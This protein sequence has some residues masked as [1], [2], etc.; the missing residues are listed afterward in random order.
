MSTSDITVA[1]LAASP[2][3]FGNVLTWTFSDPRNGALPNIALDAVEVWSSTTNDRSTA[4]KVVEG[5][6]STTHQGI[7]GE[8]VYYYWIKPRDKI[9]SYGDWYPSGATSGIACRAIGTSGLAFALMNGYVTA[10]VT[11]NALT[12]SVKTLG[13]TDP[14]ATDFISISFANADGTYTSRR[15]TTALSLVV[16][17]GSTLGTQNS[18]PFQTW[19]VIFDDAGTLRIA[20]T[21]CTSSG[22]IYPI[23]DSGTADAFAEGG[24]G[25]AD[26]FATFYANAAITG[27]SYRIIGSARWTSGL[28]VA[29]VWSVNPNNIKQFSLGSQTPGAI[30]NESLFINSILATG[31]T[32][33]PDDNTIPTVSEGF[34]HTNTPLVPTP[35]NVI[36]VEVQLPCSCTVAGTIIGA[37]NK[38]GA[39]IAVGRA[40]IS[41]ANAVATISIYFRET[42]VSGTVTYSLRLGPSS[43][44]TLTVNGVNSAGKFGGTLNSKQRFT[45]YLG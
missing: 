1:A 17:N 4:S 38:G 8:T 43:A 25:N 9:G 7:I 41:V 28:S 30:V 12:I 29:G 22:I 32:V 44:G 16:S 5:I 14:T 20:I 27:K 39:A 37:L 31:T 26:S 23:S 6:T 24:S 15:I 13:G 35:G 21:M 3:V 2:T 19:F 18:I 33:I 10:T 36:E 40:D 42:V 34:A 11:A 45:E